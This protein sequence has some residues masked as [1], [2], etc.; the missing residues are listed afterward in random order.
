MQHNS[1][2]N[3][4]EKLGE[5]DFDSEQDDVFGDVRAFPGSASVGVNVESKA[6]AISLQI[7]PLEGA[8][9]KEVY[10]LCFLWQRLLLFFKC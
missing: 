10:C 6:A 3:Q 8:A 7:P 5:K 9:R 2:R 4:L 1:T